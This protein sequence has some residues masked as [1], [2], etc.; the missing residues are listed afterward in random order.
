ML[1]CITLFDNRQLPGGCSVVALLTRIIQ[2]EQRWVIFIYTAPLYYYWARIPHEL[3][4]TAGCI[5]FFQQ[6]VSHL[7]HLKVFPLT[8]IPPQFL[9]CCPWCWTMITL[10]FSWQISIAQLERRHVAAFQHRFAV[11]R[12]IPL[13]G[14]GSKD[15][16]GPNVCNGRKSSFQS[17]RGPFR[18]CCQKK[19]K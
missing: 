15:S 12:W 6:C 8:S 10:L 13:V 14:S 7:F 9:S 18:C 2:T 16:F 4:F 3:V 11:S 5:L 19:K 1:V 17:F